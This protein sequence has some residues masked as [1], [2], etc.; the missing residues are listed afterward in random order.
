MESV[1]ANIVQLFTSGMTQDNIAHALRVSTRR[2]SRV[3]RQFLLTGRIPS[4]ARRGRPTKASNI[5]LDFIDVR[6]VQDARQSSQRLSDEM[7]ATLGIEISHDT[8]TRIR[9]KLNFKYQPPRHI[10]ALNDVQIRS[11]IDFCQKMLQM[12]PESLGLIYFSDESRIVLGSDRQW[13]WYRRGEENESANVATGKFPPSLMIF[14][15]VG[16]GYKSKL[17]LVD[18]S[19]DTDKYIENLNELNFIEDLNQLHGVLQWVFQQDGAT[20]HTSEKAME[21]IEGNCDVIADW[22]ANS[23]DLSPIELL[24]AILK[25]LVNKF[26]PKTVE[27]LNIALMKSW[28]LIGEMTIDKL[29][30]GFRE[31]LHCCLE[32]SG[33]SIGKDLF[34]LGERDAMKDFVI[35]NS[36]HKTWTAEE[37]RLL[38]EKF[39]EFGARWKVMSRFFPDR[40]SCQIKNRWY[41]VLR[42]RGVAFRSETEERILAHAQIRRRESCMQIDPVSWF[43]RSTIE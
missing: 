40:N 17:L 29:C 4:P 30:L 32:N 31:R 3:I 5:V 41:S 23:P 43:G 33:A 26:E 20:C 13:V 38:M 18:G 19:I 9:H 37:D 34:R 35:M 22:P 10:H 15:V 12:R 16:I 21:W 8:I 1:E 27:E 11:R 39:R 25:R 2:I 28:E 24:W 7:R 42:H 6:T 36:I 14:A